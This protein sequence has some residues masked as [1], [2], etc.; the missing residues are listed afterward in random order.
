MPTT[1]TFNYTGALQTFTV[2]TGVTSIAVACT[3]AGTAAGGAGDKITGTLAV[4]PGQVLNLY[5]GGQG[6][7]PAGSAGGAGGFNGGGAGGNAPGGAS[8][9]G[10]FGGGGGTDIRV[11]GTALA[12]RVCA[13]GAGAGS[14]R[15]TG[16]GGG[17][18]NTA[19]GTGTIANGNGKAGT[20][21]AGGAGGTGVPNGSAGVLG[22]G[23]AGSSSTA[24]VGGGGGGGGGYYGGGGGGNGNNVAGNATGGGGGGSNYTGGLTGAATVAAV[25]TGN[26]VITLT[27]DQPPTAPVL[28]PPAAGGAVDVTQP[29]V[30]SWTFSDPDT[31]DAQAGASVQYRVVGAGAWTDLQLIGTASSAQTATIPA[32]T[33][34]AGSTYEWRVATTDGTVAGPYSGAQ[35]FLAVSAPAAATITA[36]ISQIT[37]NPV[38]VQWTTPVG[39][40]AYQIRLV[41]DDGS[42]NA[43]TATVYSDTGQVNSAL[44]SVAVPLGTAPQGGLVHAQVRYQQ[45]AGIWSAWADSGAETVNAGPP[46]LPTLAFATNPAT[47]AIT[48]TI[49]N[50]A[51]PNA[52]VSQDLYRTDVGAV[53]LSID[54]A[55]QAA[56][57]AVADSLQAMQLIAG[58]PPPKLQSGSLAMNLAGSG[59]SRMDVQY[60]LGKRISRIRA[61]FLIESAAWTTDGATLGLLALAAPYSG[62]ALTPDSHCYLT[63]TRTSWGLG[64]ISG[65]VLTSLISGSYA[66]LALD[67]VFS[68]EV[69]INPYT[70][71]AIL[72]LPDGSVKTVT[73]ANLALVSGVV[74]DAAY[75]LNAANTDRRFRVRNL[76]ATDQ[77]DFG[78]LRIAAGLPANSSYTDYTPGSGR[79]YRY[80]VQASAF[81]GGSASSA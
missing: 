73:S 41:A 11:G 19:G 34:A 79:S 64:Y 40:V 46:G 32:N 75:L 65:G 80:R 15:G 30:L 76:W 43:V 2:P 18:A 55:A 31:G 68:I 28:N 29:T 72:W 53:P 51:L 24:N 42:G 13:A 57:P 9:S 48:V 61:E 22:V 21:A 3:G 62:G 37:T 10:G 50:P 5:V 7:S 36:P 6:G 27:Y 49:T 54:F 16:G 70:N 77:V 59:A 33:L 38:T 47:G 12:N 1:T 23:G 52:T 66:A 78:E 45:Y 60:S 81:F 25:G 63:L 74:L 56:V 14:G 20:G 35:Q 58:Q 69:A 8:G 4:T 44:Q 67:T 71:T 26:G 17:N 39:Q